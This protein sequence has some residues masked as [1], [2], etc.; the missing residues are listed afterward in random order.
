MQNQ[1]LAMSLLN[2]LNGV[3]VCKMFGG[4]ASCTFTVSLDVCLIV[5][6]KGF[7]EWSGCSQDGTS[8]VKGQ[9]NV[10]HAI[11]M[12]CSVWMWEALS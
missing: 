2:E 5:W 4:V 8:T 6:L 3:S 1:W 9:A 11:P 10:W 12:P 7:K